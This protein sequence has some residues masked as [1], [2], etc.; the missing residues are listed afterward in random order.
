MSTH[1]LS[2]AAVPCVPMAT[3]PKDS[4]AA[5]A[6]AAAAAAVTVTVTVATA[7]VP[8]LASSRGGMPTKKANHFLTPCESVSLAKGNKFLRV[9]CLEQQITR[10]C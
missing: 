8:I 3:S 2:L 4:L 10:Q 6:A 1:N 7:V 5:A 9:G